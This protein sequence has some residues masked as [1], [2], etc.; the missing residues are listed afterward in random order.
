ME[1]TIDSVQLPL[2]RI[3]CSLCSKWRILE[4]AAFQAVK[5]DAGWTCA[6]LGCAS[7]ANINCNKH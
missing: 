5:G 7:A 1:E 4:F 3:M 6:Q 2:H